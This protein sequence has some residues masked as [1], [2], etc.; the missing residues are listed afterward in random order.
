MENNVRVEEDSETHSENP[1]RNICVQTTSSVISTD[2]VPPEGWDG[3]TLQ[4]CIVPHNFCSPSPPPQPISCRSLPVV[5]NYPEP[6]A[7]SNQETEEQLCHMKLP[8]VTKCCYL[9]L[10]LT[11]LCGGSY[12][13]T[14]DNCT[15]F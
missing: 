8:V 12:G 13:N 1:A 11:V 9:Q 2:H 7:T 5:G 15:V 6:V 10:L 3:R 4:G 14:S